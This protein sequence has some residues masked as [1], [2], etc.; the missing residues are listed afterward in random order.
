[1]RLFVALVP[2]DDAVEDLAGFLEPRREA[3]PTLRW[4]SSE[5][6]H[7]TLAFMA[8]VDDRH[9]DDLLERLTR[10]AARRHAFSASM[11][12]G[13]AF[14]N[15]ARGRV[16]YAGVDVGDASQELDRLVTGV[17][18]AAN[19]AGAAAEG[20]GF[21][22]H[23]TLAR[24]SRPVDLTRWVRVLDGYAGPLWPAG[25][26]AL[27]ESHLGEGPGGRP[28]HDVLARFPLAAPPAG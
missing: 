26:L 16:L 6:W 7:L 24:V 25:E 22:P 23:L 20:G 14:P 17:R 4:T 8:S 5:Q 3:D 18:A 21:H 28:R 19:R 27:V 9:L 13:G 12:G 10:A 2:P 15:V 11:V 1:M